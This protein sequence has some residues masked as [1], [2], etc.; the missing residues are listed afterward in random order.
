[1][2]IYGWIIMFASIGF[3]L[4]LTTYCYVKVLSLPPLEADEQL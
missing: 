3:V 1:M 4:I 2:T